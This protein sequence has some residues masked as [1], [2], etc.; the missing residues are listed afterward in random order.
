LE[1]G[2]GD[3]R[4]PGHKIQRLS[5]QQ[6]RH[7]GHHALNGK[8]LRPISFDAPSGFRPSS[9]VISSPPV[10]VQFTAAGCLT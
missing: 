2:D 5:A 3:I 6:T 9:I 7:Y 10:A 1:L 4:F 8:T